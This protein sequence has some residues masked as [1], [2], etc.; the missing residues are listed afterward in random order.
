MAKDN[1]IHIK[2][3]YGEAINS[4]R[5]ILSLEMSILRLA[6]TIENYKH[7]KR[8]EFDLKEEIH[9]KTKET[10]STIRRLERILP[11]S[12]V[13]SKFR[14]EESEKEEKVDKKGK[15]THIKEE[16]KDIETQLIEIQKR[17]NALQNKNF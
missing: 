1:L 10:A 16:D 15:K 13:P 3:D 12:K 14:K 17:L 6:K 2:M 9:K 11:K 4:K 5:D 7:L 8:K